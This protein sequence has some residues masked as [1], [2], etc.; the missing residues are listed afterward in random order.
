MFKAALSIFVLPTTALL[1]SSPA[2]SLR[3]MGASNPGKAVA[4]RRKSRA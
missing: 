2:A 1:F 3:F 4:H